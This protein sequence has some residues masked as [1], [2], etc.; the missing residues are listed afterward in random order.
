MRI[1]SSFIVGVFSVLSLSGFISNYNTTHSRDWRYDASTKEAVLY[2]IKD[3]HK[4][5]RTS[6]VVYANKF[7]APTMNYYIKRNHA[8]IHVLTKKPKHNE[9]IQYFYLF[10]GT[11]IN[12]HNSSIKKIKPYPLSYSKVVLLKKPKLHKVLIKNLK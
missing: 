1:F 6:T 4:S 7:F 3:T 9:D 11:K 2:I 5:N 8:N 12:V 10:G